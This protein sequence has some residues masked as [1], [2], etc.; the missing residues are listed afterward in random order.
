M[1]PELTLALDLEFVFDG[2][3]L[4][5]TGFVLPPPPQADK[6]AAIA[7]KPIHKTDLR[8]I[9]SSMKVQPGTSIPSSDCLPRV[10]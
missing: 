8:I 3:V 5:V 7:T 1:V 10:A 6:E 9:R 4:F 2:V